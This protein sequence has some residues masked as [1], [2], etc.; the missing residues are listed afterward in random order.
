MLKG[1]DKIKF[2]QK[3]FL[4]HPRAQGCPLALKVQSFVATYRALGTR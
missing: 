3:L 2:C 4:K 1:L